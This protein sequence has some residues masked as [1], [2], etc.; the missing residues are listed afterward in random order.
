MIYQAIRKNQEKLE[1]SSL[2]RLFGVSRGAYYHHLRANN[3]ALR[4]T[5]EADLR[6][7]IEKIILEF[8]GYGYRR[9]TKALKR[10]GWKVNHKRV[11]RVMREGSLLCR[12]KKSWVR[13]TDSNH[14]HTIYP[15]LTKDFIPTTPNQLWVADITYI[16]LLREF[17]YLSVILDAFSR[18]VIGWHLSKSIDHELALSA[19]KMALGRREIQPGLIHHSD[20]GV[21]YACQ[22]YI[23]M[24]KDHGIFT[25]M[26]AKGNPYE[27]AQAESFFATLKKE[28]VYLCE[29][30]TF[31]EA[32]MRIGEFIEEVYNR[33]RL[34]SS[35]DYLPPVEFEE[36]LT[37]VE[38]S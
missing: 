22:E 27:N 20:R 12:L 34:H 38:V 15:N 17:V 30:E 13:T 25:S 23:Q 6:D 36:R 21:Q 11:L 37:L 8:P 28:E 10:Q 31:K 3:K 33:K 16:R 7:Q 9:V 35:L 32:R 19:L 5:Q 29:Y 14:D 2:C 4:G 1:V 18:K 24:L 26:S